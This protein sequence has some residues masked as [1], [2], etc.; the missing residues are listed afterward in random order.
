VQE[1][2]TS[3]VEQRETREQGNAN[4]GQR[5]FLQ[6]DVCGREIILCVGVGGHEPHTWSCDGFC[7]MKQNEPETTY[8]YYGLFL[9]NVFYVEQQCDISVSQLLRNSCHKW[10]VK[11]KK[12]K[13]RGMLAK[14]SE[15]HTWFLAR[16]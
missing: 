16:F 3:T 5:G 11:S 9:C 13:K 15:R 8:I 10:I 12:S 2:L 14:Y 4:G 6:D 1:E 7:M